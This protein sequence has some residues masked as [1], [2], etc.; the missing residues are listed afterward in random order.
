MTHIKEAIKAAQAAGMTA[1]II[2]LSPD[3][4]E[5]AE[6][7]DDPE[8]I[9]YA[10][11]AMTAANARAEQLLRERDE[12]REALAKA[13]AAPAANVEVEKL[14]EELRKARAAAP[15]GSD[16][17]TI[18]ELEATIEALRSDLAK[19]DKEIEGLAAAGVPT[20]VDDAGDAPLGSFDDYPI[21]VLGLEKKELKGAE[22]CGCK[23]V[24]DARKALLNGDLKDKGRLPKDSVITVANKLL[25]AAPSG[26]AANVIDAPAASTAPA[27]H[28]DRTW[29]ERLGAAFRKEE[30]AHE[31]RATLDAMIA[32]LKVLQGQQGVKAQVADLQGKI[33]AQDKMLGMY[34]GQICAVLWSL[35][36][37]HDFAKYGSVDGALQAAGLAHLMRGTPAPETT[38]P[39]GG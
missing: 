11:G 15:D 9:A 18:A 1:T 17:R 23:T 32:Q 7:Q 28:T 6:P 29:D 21:S 34:D 26:K 5:P 4:A 24:G 3:G 10:E 35:N 37:P 20:T 13:Q 33:A 8:D 36:L 27:G 38:P 12:A 2:F 16:A 19:K 14:K 30:K 31:I 39:A 22:K 25:G